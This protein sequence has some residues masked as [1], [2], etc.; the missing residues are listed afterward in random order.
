VAAQAHV[1][2]VM[3]DATGLE[4]VVRWESKVEESILF[5][6]DS[7]ELVSVRMAA[8]EVVRGRLDH[9]KQGGYIIG[10]PPPGATD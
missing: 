3:L 8:E 10:E 7:L 1:T 9:L 2:S 5:D 4:I 6:P